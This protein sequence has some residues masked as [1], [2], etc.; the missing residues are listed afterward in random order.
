MSGARSH[1]RRQVPDEH[2]VLSVRCWGVQLTPVVPGAARRSVVTNVP[3]SMPWRPSVAS[4]C[5]ISSASSLRRLSVSERQ[6][7]SS[8]VER[9][10]IASPQT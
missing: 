6:S 5:R 2:S 4:L 10:P 7:P 9:W 1:Q 3:V 8:M